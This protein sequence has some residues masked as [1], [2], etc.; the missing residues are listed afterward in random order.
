MR[1]L[2]YD[3]PEDKVCWDNESEMMYGPDILVAPVMER[4]QTT[5]EVYLPAGASWTHIWSGETYEGGQTVA[6][7]APLDKL[8]VFTKNDF[9][10][11]TVKEN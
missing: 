2:F 5:K 10:L 6:V 8:P 7:D 4:G 11:S 9:R 3:F 1:P